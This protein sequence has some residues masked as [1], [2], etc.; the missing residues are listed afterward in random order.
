M[1]IEIKDPET[2][3]VVRELARRLNTGPE[4]AVRRVSEQALAGDLTLPVDVAEIDRILDW[5]W[6][7]PVKDARPMDELMAD[8]EPR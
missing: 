4:E 2:E 3:R 1:T 5:F 8:D 7:Q 6:E